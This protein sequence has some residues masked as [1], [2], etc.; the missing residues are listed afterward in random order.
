MSL[1]DQ[2][3]I[4]GTGTIK[5]GENFEQSYT[6]MVYEAAT[7]AMVD[8]SVEPAEIQAGWLGT[9]EPLLY[10]YEGNAG[11][12]VADT[13]GLPPI[14]ITR[15][16]A[17]CASGLEAVRNAALAVASGEYD[18][19]LAVGAEKMRDVPARGSLVALA[20]ERG[21]PVL[22]K[23]RTAPGMFA[24]L[25]TRYFREYGATEEALAHVAVKN[26][27]HGSLNPKAHFRKAITPEQHARAPKVAEPLRLYDCCP[28]TDGAAACVLTRTD[29]AARRGRPYVR[30]RGIAFSVAAGYWNT[31]FDPSWGFTS[32]RATRAAARAAY[33]MAGIVDP[34][35]EIDVAECHDCFTI[36]EIVNYEDL[37]FARPGEGHKLAAAGVTR[38]GGD[39]PIN[40]SGGHKSCGHPIGASGVRML[41]HVTDQLLGRAGAMQVRGART[42]LAHNLGGPGSVA[43]V[44]VLGAP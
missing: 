17:Y 36:T 13:L 12:F 3:A 21:H 43:A 19:V 20:M 40:T 14:P 35:R 25:A 8:A 22:C 10:G 38:L 16:A 4:I 28:T 2:V 11:P 37:G 41:N 18:L 30:I 24:L 33:R 5:F 32:F 31:Q 44:A 26:H 34:S 7:A 1:A 15:V 9:Y 29:L 42:G 6:D 39:L 27:H 23:G